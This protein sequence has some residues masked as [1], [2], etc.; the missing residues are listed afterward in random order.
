[1]KDIAKNTG[2]KAV[3]K[4][5][6]VAIPPEIVVTPREAFYKNKRSVSLDQSIGEIAGEMI[7]A[8]PPGIPVIGIGERITKDII[9]YIRILKE[10]RCQLQGAADSK[11]EYITIISKTS[12]D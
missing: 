9:D 1:M 2:I 5:T 11:I 12:D 10:E 8:Y 6:V 3:S 7:M 4:K